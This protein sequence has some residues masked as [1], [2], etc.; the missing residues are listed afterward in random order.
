MSGRRYLV[1]FA[2]ALGLAGVATFGVYGLVRSDE[3]S[4][5]AALRSVA[6]VVKPVAAGAMVPAGAVVLAQWPAGSIPSGAFALIDSVVGR[7]ALVPLTKGVPVVPTQLAARGAAP[8]LEGAILAGRR[9]MTVRVS[10]AVGASGML[11]AD[12]RVDVLVTLRDEETGTRPRARLV[13]SDVRVLAVGTARPPASAD[14]TPRAPSAAEA[15]VVTLEVTPTQAEQL[16]VVESQGSIQLVLRGYGSREQLVTSGT[17]TRD[18]LGLPQQL[19]APANALANV[20]AQIGRVAPMRAPVRH[21]ARVTTPAPGASSDAGRP[22]A[23]PPT[24][25]TTTV[26]VFRGGKLT[27]EQVETTDRSQSPAVVLGTAATP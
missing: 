19:T 21:V 9:A 10:E 6:V 24:P 14:E 5:D 12:S 7:V 23:P 4:A 17:T 8:G 27:I 22:S 1:L 20:A 3:P 2:G 26:R 16:A 13:M 25:E 18:V 11:R 15:S